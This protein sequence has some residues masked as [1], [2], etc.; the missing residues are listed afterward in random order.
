M[1]ESLSRKTALGVEADLSVPA[2]KIL[3]YLNRHP[4]AKDNVL[5]V[6]R[7]WLRTD[8]Y[9]AREALIELVR[10]KLIGERDSSSG[11]LYFRTNETS[12]R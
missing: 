1:A 6:A 3:D 12:R 10:L 5:G 2:R 8:V 7:W 11:T 4:L 9:T